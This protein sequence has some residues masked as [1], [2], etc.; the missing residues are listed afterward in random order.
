MFFCNREP[1]W[2]YAA[3]VEDEAECPYDVLKFGF[4][5]IILGTIG[6]SLVM[7]VLCYVSYEF[8]ACS[9]MYKTKVLDILTSLLA[10]YTVIGDYMWIVLLQMNSVHALHATIFM[11]GLCH[12]FLC[13][14]I[15]ALSVRITITSYIQDTPWWRRNRKRLR[16][17]LFLSCV[18]PRFFRITRAQIFG[19]D[20]TQIHFG[21][22]SKMAVVFSNLGLVML[23]QDIL[24]VLLQ[25]YIWLI[26]R[27]Q[28][29]KVSLICI[30]LG[31]Q[32]ITVAI[33]H[34]VFSRSQR[35]AYE[36]VVKL[37]GVRRLTAG[38]FDVSSTGTVGTAGREAN[39]SIGL[40]KA[41]GGQETIDMGEDEDENAGPL[42]PTK[43]DPIQAALYVSQMYEKETISSKRILKDEDS[44][45]EEDGD[46]GNAE[47]AALPAPVAEKTLYP[48][49]VFEKMKKFY[50]VHDP[51][52]LAT[53]GLGHAPDFDEAELDQELKAKFGQGLD[54][55]S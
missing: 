14:C 53:I 50:S 23:F 28:G 34:H 33:L 47:T 1:L 25:T 15:N 30:L 12:L 43:L 38:F 46:G 37:L 42:D 35:A 17:I 39:N 11:G 48:K 18:S 16:T 13:F 36:R 22:P 21:T 26:W 5:I 19:F 6:V 40:R 2:E 27:N 24:Q 3:V 9:F 20:T 29:P 7:G 54:S 45:E 51:A 41:G 4:I 44:E 49:A 31:A 32:S 10:I 8:A 55:V 52:K